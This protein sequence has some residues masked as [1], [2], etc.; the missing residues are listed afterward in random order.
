MKLHRLNYQQSLQTSLETA[1]DFFSDPGNLARITP[2]W[3]GF[4]IVSDL[5]PEIHP[6]LL[7][8]YRIRPLPAIPWTWITEIIEVDRPLCFVDEQRSGP[9]RLWRHRHRFVA[10]EGGVEM[11]DE[12]EYALPLGFF[13]NLLH[14]PLVRPRL[15]EIFAYRRQVLTKIFQEGAGKFPESFAEGR[16]RE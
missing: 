7:I 14:R 12:V 3:L 4:R 15:E 2:P 10:K 5:P 1:W 13:G 8:T 11:T 6:G 9:Y 16:N